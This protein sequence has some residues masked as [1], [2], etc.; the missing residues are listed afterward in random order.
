MLYLFASSDSD[1]QARRPHS[2]IL[3]SPLQ[4]QRRMLSL[5][6]N[7]QNIREVSTDA[8][9]VKACKVIN[10]VRSPQRGNYNKMATISYKP[11]ILP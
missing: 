11:V 6:K 2:V 3:R 1:S 8:N 10:V 9:T 4:L 5:S 7:K